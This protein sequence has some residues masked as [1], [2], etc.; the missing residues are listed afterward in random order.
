M[1]DTK[2]KSI[3]WSDHWY[4]NW[5]NLANIKSK[6][7]EGILFTF[8]IQ[9]NQEMLTAMN[10]SKDTGM[11]LAIQ[12]FVGVVVAGSSM[13]GALLH[14]ATVNAFNEGFETDGLGSRY[15]VENASDDG[16]DFFARRQEF[17]AGTRISGGNIEGS[18]FWTG[19][20]IDAAGE[21]DDAVGMILDV[22]VEDAGMKTCVDAFRRTRH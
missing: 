3:L 21:G 6:L 17:S 7:L 1:Y 13:T 20:D 18:Y 10:N 19:R 16:S 4:E 9:E 12:W 15:T 22:V 11:K 2:K 5:N 8:N 14:G